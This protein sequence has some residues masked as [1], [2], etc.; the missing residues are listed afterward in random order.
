M[1]QSDGSTG[2]DLLP[3][4]SRSFS[5]YGWR[6]ASRCGCTS[7]DSG[8]RRAQVRTT[9]S[10]LVMTGSGG[11]KKEVVRPYPRRCNEPSFSGFHQ[12][13]ATARRAIGDAGELVD[14]VEQVRAR[15][16]RPDE[17]A[18]DDETEDRPEPEPLNRVTHRRRRG[19]KDDDREKNRRE[20]QQCLLRL[21][22][23]GSTASG[24]ARRRSRR[25]AVHEIGAMSLTER[26]SMFSA[27]AIC[28]FLDPLRT[29]C[30]TRARAATAAHSIAR[31]PGVASV[32]A[33]PPRVLARARS[34][35]PMIAS[36]A[37]VLTRKSHAAAHGLDAGG[38]C[39]P[40]R[41]EDD[42]QGM[43]DPPGAAAMRCR[44]S[45]ACG[46][47]PDTTDG[48]RRMVRNEFHRRSVA[49]GGE[50]AAAQQ[51]LDAL[52]ERGV[53]V[54]DEHRASLLGHAASPWSAIGSEN[55]TRAP[56]VGLFSAWIRPPCA[57]TMV[58]EIDSP[59]PIPSALV[60]K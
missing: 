49:P 54:D 57:S 31:A 35:A 22:K 4:V 52:P 13:G 7:M 47:P 48:V 26:S 32:P 42:G 5:G 38:G 24:P 44:P 12:G 2:V 10:V 20:V 43:A 41:S 34:T 50:A 11:D 19:N 28:L 25:R 6:S 58:R 17:H 55:Q 3:S 53:V 14:R 8:R 45:P 46:D 18:G 39:R 30:S 9:A 29:W 27:S 59:R 1:S 37:A 40:G 60:V 33:A 51:T 36:F 21:G 23:A 15:C 16:I 56:P